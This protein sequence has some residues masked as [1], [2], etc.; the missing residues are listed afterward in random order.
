[1][2]KRKSRWEGMPYRVY[3]RDDGKRASIHGAVPWTSEAEKSRWNMET[4]GWTVYDSHTGTY[5][6]GRPPFKTEAELN[7]W[8]DKEY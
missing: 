5:G 7:E 2:R 4:Y 1:M 3:V 8:L 6:I